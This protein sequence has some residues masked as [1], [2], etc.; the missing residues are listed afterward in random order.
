MN[1]A[2]F[3]KLC[4]IAHVEA[5]IHLK[6]GKEALVAARVA[7]RLRLLG[8][9]SE[10]DYLRVL[11]EDKSGEELVCFLDAISTNFTSFMREPDHFESLSCW[12]R[13]NQAR[14]KEPLRL[15]CAAAATGEEPYSIAI[16]L[17]E[18]LEGRNQRF[19]ILA[20]DIST[21]ALGCAAAGEYS[22]TGIAPLSSAQRSKHFREVRGG[23]SG[24]K[25]QVCP[26]VRE[27]IVYRRL[28]L[29]APPFPM[30]GP[31]DVVF[32]RNVMIYFDRNTRQKLISEIERLL[33]PGGIL[34]TGHSESLAGIHSG[35]T[36]LRPSV[37]Q[38]LESNR[39]KQGG[40]P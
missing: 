40:R 15:W 12:A 16:T 22:E 29:A 7:K 3:N 13:Q 17:L 35:L 31:L 14:S 23:A 28:N 5:G 27:T 18:A 19:K 4:S 33:A 37:Y 34:Y 11:E 10:R 30:K 20:T 39:V 6:E 24:S 25:Y 26:K 21:R 1:S 38:K 8:L 9:S 2:V 32:C 36:M